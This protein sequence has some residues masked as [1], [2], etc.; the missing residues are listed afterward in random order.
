MKALPELGT[1]LAGWRR[2]AEPGEQ[3]RRGI[4]WSWNGSGIVSGSVWCLLSVS[5]ELLALPRGLFA[6]AQLRTCSCLPGEAP[7]AA[8]LSWQDPAWKGGSLRIQGA[9]R[10]LQIKE[11]A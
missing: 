3:R 5:S 10:A 4:V 6:L 2:L 11:G 9:P 7:E 1:A 8:A